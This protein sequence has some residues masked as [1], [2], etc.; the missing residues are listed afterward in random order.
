[1]LQQGRRFWKGEPLPY[2]HIRRVHLPHLGEAHDLLHR[3]L[4]ILPGSRSAGELH[5]TILHGPHPE[6]RPIEQALHLVA[7]AVALVQGGVDLRLVGIRVY[8]GVGVWGAG[9]GRGEF[10]ILIVYR[11]V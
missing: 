11:L 5:Y 4:Q 6:S 7:Q 3:P 2:V 9:V 10:L 1:M 8:V